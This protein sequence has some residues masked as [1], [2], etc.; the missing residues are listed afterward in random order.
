MTACLNLTG[1][2]ILAIAPEEP[3]RLFSA[4]ETA[5]A[6]Y[7]IL[8]QRWHP[9][10]ALATPT[11]FDPDDAPPVSVVQNINALWAAA[12]Q[13][14]AAGVWIAPGVARLT[15]ADGRHFRLRYVRRRSFELGE[16]LIGRTVV[17]FLIARQHEPLLANARRR[18]AA[19]PFA[20]RAMRAEMAPRL[21]Q[22]QADFVTC[23]TDGPYVLVLDKP[24]DMVA[25]ADLLDHL[26]GR[27][28]PQH[29]AWM[30]SCLLHQACYLEWAGL[31]H[32]ALG[33]ETWFVHPASHAGALLGGW[34]YAASEGAR[35]TSL[36]PRSFAAAPPDLRADK[37]ARHGFDLELI[38]LTG[39]ELLG[40]PAGTR[41]PRDPD[42]PEPLADWLLHPSSGSALEDYQDWQAVLYASF[43]PKR[44]IQL[45]V[46]ATDVYPG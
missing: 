7:R 46:G 20:D 32:N 16:M 39:R 6:E 18:I 26:G 24:A 30:L 37:T 45:G 31:T 42:V 34:W 4:P 29:V 40:D 3:E 23:G 21:P 10:G 27:L 19:L 11:T 43:G 13:K 1:W 8:M 2:E 14:I 38:R 17:G 36:P 33:A 12:E 9:D 22:I 5:K 44:F 35:L 25:L 28:P 15:A 41:L